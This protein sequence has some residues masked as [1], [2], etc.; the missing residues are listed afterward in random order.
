M[1]DTASVRSFA[2]FTEARQAIAEFRQRARAAI[3]E[4]GGEAARVRQWIDHDCHMHWRTQ[5]RVRG[6][7][8][9]VAKSELSRVLLGMHGEASGRE[10][11][12]LVA[13]AELQ[14][15]EAE[16][17][18]RG[19]GHWLREVERADTLYRGGIQPLARAVEERLMRAESRLVLLLDRLQA[20]LKGTAAPPERTTG[21]AGAAATDG[22]A[23]ESAEESTP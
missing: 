6:E 7:R 13:R 3:D 1:R 2:A 22:S 14:L 19:L 18:A 17:K 8:L 23:E 15:A 10:Q 11:R 16:Q 9:A 4:A 5:V 20:Y 21:D 12:A